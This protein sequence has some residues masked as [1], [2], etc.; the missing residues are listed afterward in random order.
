MNFGLVII[1]KKASVLQAN[2][3]DYVL[4][5]FE[6]ISVDYAAIL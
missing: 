5:I 2:E 4:K 6:N 3:L 1:T